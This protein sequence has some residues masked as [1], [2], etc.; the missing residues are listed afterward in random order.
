MTSANAQFWLE[1]KGCLASRRHSEK[2]LDTV[3]PAFEEKGLCSGM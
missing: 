3:L 2:A 1:G